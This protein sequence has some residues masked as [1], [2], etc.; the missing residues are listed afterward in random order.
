MN[1]RR[2]NLREVPLD[3]VLPLR[4]GTVY[5]TMSVGQRDTFLRAA[6]EANCVLLE[7][8]GDEDLVAAYRRPP[9]TWN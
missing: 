9:V 6:Y 4:P 3:T 2:P 7:V 5:L 8:D 1:A